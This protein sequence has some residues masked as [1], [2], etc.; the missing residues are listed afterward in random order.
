VTTRWDVEHALRDSGLPAAARLIEHVLLTRTDNGGTT[1]PVRFMPSLADLAHDTG[2]SRRSVIRAL[3]VLE[4]GG[5]L[6]RRRDPER[7]RKEGKPTSYRP[8]LPPSARAA[9]G[10]VPEG[11]QAS[12]GASDRAGVTVARKARTPEHQTSSAPQRTTRTGSRGEPAATADDEDHPLEHIA[13]D[14][15]AILDGLPGVDGRLREFIIA[16]FEDEEGIRGEALADRLLHL[17]GEGK[18]PSLASR[19]AGP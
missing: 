2:L 1:I 13:R 9:L 14:P 16:R 4:S 17:I 15:R 10:L 5:W 3:D 19:R 11:H 7:A 12:D 18:A 8:K 6:T